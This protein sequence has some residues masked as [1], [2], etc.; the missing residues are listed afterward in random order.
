MTKS[1]S[2]CEITSTATPRFSFIG[3]S[4]WQCSHRCTYRRH[5]QRLER[6]QAR[7]QLR[8][9]AAEL[10]F[11]PR[12]HSFRANRAHPDGRAVITGA[13][14]KY[15]S[16]A[17]LEGTPIGISRI[18]SGSQTMAYVMARQQGWPMDTLRFKGP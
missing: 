8:Q 18:G 7:R 9:H 6:I 16:I 14:S 11:L 17:D 1:T 3:S 2:Q 15:Q 12:M 5:S 4:I 10:V 13:Q